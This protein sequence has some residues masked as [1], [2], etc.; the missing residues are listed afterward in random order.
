MVKIAKNVTGKDNE[1]EAVKEF[2]SKLDSPDNYFNKVEFPA[3]ESDDQAHL[4]C[5]SIEGAKEYC[6]MRWKALQSWFRETRM[7]MYHVISWCMRGCRFFKCTRGLVSKEIIVLRRWGSGK[8]YLTIIPRAR[9][10]YEMI[11]SQRGA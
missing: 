6:P 2:R 5:S 3:N 9:V 7:V 1:T 10:G 11:D 4:R 8:T